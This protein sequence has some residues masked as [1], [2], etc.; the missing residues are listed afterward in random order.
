MQREMDAK[1][2]MKWRAGSSLG[3]TLYLDDACVGM[4]DTRE[5]ALTVIAAMN[6][7]N[8][9][10]REALRTE[11]E[12]L[13]PIVDATVAWVEDMGECHFCGFDADSPTPVHD[14]DCPLRLLELPSA[15]TPTSSTIDAEDGASAKDECTCGHPREHHDRDDGSCD[16]GAHGWAC[17]CASFVLRRERDLAHDEGR[18]GS[19]S[20]REG[21]DG[22]GASSDRGGGTQAGDPVREVR[23]D[24]RAGALDH[25]PGAEGAV[26]A[27]SPYAGPTSYTVTGEEF[28]WL[29]CGVSE[30]MRIVCEA[31]RVVLIDADDLAGNDQ[32]QNVRV[33]SLDAL[34]TALKGADDAAA[35]AKNMVATHAPS[36]R[37][38]RDRKCRSRSC[39]GDDCLGCAWLASVDDEVKRRLA[40]DRPP[41][42]LKCQLC[43]NMTD[44]IEPLGPVCAGRARN[45]TGGT[46]MRASRARSAS[47]TTAKGKARGPVPS[48]RC[49]RRSRG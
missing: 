40:M 34:R 14:T 17:G 35:H 28:V 23:R 41:L 15:S 12:R 16:Y 21:R 26:V 5:L 20:A 47:R 22:V 1:V 44:L 8:V 3:R 46:T 7:N 36:P 2:R 29:M 18:A 48:T 4:L 24:G 37:P 33:A 30:R 19:V 42:M 49:S 45:L 25:V 38:S 10:E 11:N 27:P 31:A 6:G 9:V 32:I 13:R 43:E 39:S